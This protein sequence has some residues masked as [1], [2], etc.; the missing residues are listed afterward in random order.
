[1]YIEFEAKYGHYLAKRVKK[2]GK[3]EEMKARGSPNKLGDLLLG[4]GIAFCSTVL[5]YE[6]KD[7]NDNRKE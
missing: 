6:E 1:M 4:V 7:Q 5:S 3:N 2:D